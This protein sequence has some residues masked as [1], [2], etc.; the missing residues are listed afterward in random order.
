M[1]GKTWKTSEYK[2]K[3]LVERNVKVRMSDGV[4]LNADIF[5]PD[6]NEKFPAVFGFHPYDQVCQTAPITKSAL[7]TNFFKNPGQEK[8]NA[9]IEAG[10]PDAYVRRGYVYVIANV[11]GTG[12]SGGKYPFL[13]EPE[14]V[15]LEEHGQDLL[16]SITERAQQHCHRQLAAAVDAGEQQVLGI[17]FNIQPGAAIGDDAG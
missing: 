13:A 14:G 9:F 5:R 1:F 2:Y 8:G 17:E 11:R 4:E 12:K 7:S 16:G 10:D 3:V 6:S 15:G